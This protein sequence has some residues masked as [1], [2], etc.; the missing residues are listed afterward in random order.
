M[1][2]TFKPLSDHTGIEVEGLDLSQ[3]LSSETRERVYQAWL[4]HSVLVVRDQNLNPHE[5]LAAAKQFG[6]P[7]HQHNT[8]FQL[9]ECP[10]IHYISNQDK[11]EDGRRYIPGSG[12]HTDHSNAANPPKATILHAKSLP[13]TG[14]DTQFVN[15]ARAFETLDIDIQKRINGLKAEHVYQS[16]HSSRK[17]VG[18]TEQRKAEIEKSVSHP[19]IRTHDETARKAIYINPIRIERIIGMDDE[20]ALPLLDYLLEH[21]IQIM[22]EYRHRWE[23]GDFVMWDNRVLLHKANPDYDMKERRYLYRLMLQGP[24]PS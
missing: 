15:M 19:L 23:E 22:H 20:E 17:L 11:Y 7:L 24:R 18:L 1:S 9:E 13:K 6:D 4:E 14:G 12:Y 5:L 3:P 16:S 21:S 8:R 2:I 10:E